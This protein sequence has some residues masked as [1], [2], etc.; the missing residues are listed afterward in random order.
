MPALPQIYPYKAGLVDPIVMPGETVGVWV[1]KVF[2]FYKVMYIEGLNRSD[3]ITIDL[4]AIAAGAASAITQLLILEM[5]TLEF[6]QFRMEVLDDVAVVLYQGRA[7]QR[8]KLMNTVANVSRF[9]HLHD[10]C[11]HQTEFYVHE[12]NWAFIQA[13]NQTLYALTQ[14]RVAFWGFRYVLEDFRAGVYSWKEQR[15][16]E[17]WTRVPATAHL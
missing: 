13:T 12:N 11:A 16:P 2:E 5:P 3:P 4:G 7:D 10:P 8:H 6:G 17:M 15:L 14:A 9:T 1:N